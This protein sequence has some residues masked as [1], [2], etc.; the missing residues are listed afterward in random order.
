MIQYYNSHKLENNF[1]DVLTVS[2]QI[3]QACTPSPAL[4]L[5]LLRYEHCDLSEYELSALIND[6]RP[7]SVHTKK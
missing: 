6:K 5:D 2:V 7:K 3:S 4:Q 1:L